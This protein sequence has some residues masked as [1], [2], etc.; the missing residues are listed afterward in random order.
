MLLQTNIST[1][2]GLSC[3]HGAIRYLLSFTNEPSQ[4]GCNENLVIN[5]YVVLRTVHTLSAPCLF[6]SISTYQVGIHVLVPVAF[7]VSRA[8]GTTGPWRHL[9]HN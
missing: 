4:Q 6:L 9:H 7:S 1:T 5:S 8:V 3:M 2:L